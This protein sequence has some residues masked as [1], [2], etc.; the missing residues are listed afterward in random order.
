MTTHIQKLDEIKD[1]VRMLRQELTCTGDST[2]IQPA[3]EFERIIAAN[4][5]AVI[6]DMDTELIEASTAL[7]D[8]M[9]G[10]IPN[11]LVGRLIHDLVPE[12][13]REKHREH[14]QTFRADPKSRA[15]GTL[16]MVLH[17][18]K[19]DGTLINV[20]IGLSLFAWA[21]KRLV[22]ATILKRRS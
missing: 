18:V 5:P 10:Y 9:F 16:D 2:P 22:I 21:G 1:S 20:E 7:A 15:M 12:G 19:K 17:G 13:L 8:E 6:V 14:M 4:V 3:Y 11:E